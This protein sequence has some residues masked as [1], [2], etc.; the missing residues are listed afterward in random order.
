M[1]FNRGTGTALELLASMVQTVW[2]EGKDQVAF[3]SPLIS[4]G[5]FQQLITRA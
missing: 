3:F 5:P 4:Q 1:N 2:K